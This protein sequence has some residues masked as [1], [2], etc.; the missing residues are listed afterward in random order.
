MNKQTVQ[1]K[2]LAFERDY[3]LLLSTSKSIVE[4]SSDQQIFLNF[5]LQKDYLKA[6]EVFPL[7]FAQSQN[8]QEQAFVLQWAVAASELLGDMQKR[9]E[10]L[11]FW[12]QVQKWAIDSYSVYLKTFHQGMSLFSDGY[13]RE[14]EF[15]FQRIH[16]V[17]LQ[18]Q[19]PRGQIRALLH[20]GLVYRDLENKE[21][22]LSFL[23]K[24]Q[25]LAI[26]ENNNRFIERI[27]RISSKL[28]GNR[29]DLSMFDSY[30]LNIETALFQ[31]DFL[32]ARI[33]LFHAE[34]ERRRQGLKRRAQSLYIYLPALF[35]G[36]GKTNLSSRLLNKIDDPVLQ[37]YAFELKY[38]SSDLNQTELE[39]FYNLRAMQGLSGRV[40]QATSDIEYSEICG[41]RVDSIQDQSVKEFCKLLLTEKR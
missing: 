12:R 36:L 34:K 3:D 21:K 24:A 28:I 39:V 19:Y 37:I 27:Q 15:C 40:L 33:E 1:N 31:K 11:Q 18:M 16:D 32:R 41:V 23:Q 13:L 17:T 38:K 5:I 6:L 2:I 4:F 10:V 22:A 20:L 14:A 7:A 9:A 29:Q 30:K 35:S 25:E 8:T 26:A